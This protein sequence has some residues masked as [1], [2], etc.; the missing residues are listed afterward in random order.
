MNFLMSNQDNK[1]LLIPRADWNACISLVLILLEI[2]FG[3]QRG[4]FGNKGQ[5]KSAPWLGDAAG[6]TVS[7]GHIKQ[8]ACNS[9]AFTSLDYGWC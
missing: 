8:L 7:A 1:E 6:R 2:R 5:S 9:A 3:L 4:L